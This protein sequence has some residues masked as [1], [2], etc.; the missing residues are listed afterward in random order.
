MSVGPLRSYRVTQLSHSLHGTGLLSPN[1]PPPAASLGFKPETAL[2]VAS[3]T[4][5]TS[6]ALATPAMLRPD[7]LRGLPRH[8]DANTTRAAQALTVAVANH[9]WKNAN[10]TAL[11]LSAHL[12]KH[13]GTLSVDAQD[14]VHLALSDALGRAEA[15]DAWSFIE[16]L[17]GIFGLGLPFLVDVLTTTDV[18]RLLAR[19]SEQR[20]AMSRGLASQLVRSSSGADA[21]DAAVVAQE[22]ANL[23]PAILRT[24]TAGGAVVYAVRNNIFD[25]MD[26]DLNSLPAEIRHGHG[27]VMGTTDRATNR[28]NIRTES[29][30]VGS[31]TIPHP[32]NMNTGSTVLHEAMH[33]Y[34]NL[35]GGASRT[36]EFMS[37]L[38]AD[39]AALTNYENQ[40]DPERRRREAYAE[41]CARYL[42]GD[43]SLQTS[44]PN[45]WRYCL[46][47]FGP[48]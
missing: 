45:L 25:G 12:A 4:G 34:D 48:R 32:A 30:T 47:M 13:S 19:S 2:A 14:D 18:E 11:L 6:G 17:L 35:T 26:V 39:E 10:R 36:P 41:T 5:T 22:L 43:H 40:P 8:T 21:A 37:A 16:I 23:P 31:P 29:W 7:V 33:A 42:G 44:R 24:L 27:K 15:A 1:P 38:V 20:L 46:T 9:D 3:A 28:I